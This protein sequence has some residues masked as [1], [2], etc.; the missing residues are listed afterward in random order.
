MPRRGTRARDRRAHV[1]CSYTS[2]SLDSLKPEPQ[3]P[4]KQQVTELGKMAAG[5]LEGP[6]GKKIAL[7]GVDDAALS[8]EFMLDK[9]VPKMRLLLVEVEV[10]SRPL[11][12]QPRA[13]APAAPRTAPPQRARR[14]PCARAVG[15]H[16]TAR[17]L[18]ELPLP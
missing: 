16:R 9:H 18:Q 6:N 3:R 10:C 17:L 1:L 8:A 7:F 4:S 14:L 2:Q 15:R 5:K 11:G 13:C 12:C